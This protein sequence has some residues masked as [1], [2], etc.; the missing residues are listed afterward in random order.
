MAKKTTLPNMEVKKKPR[1]RRKPMSEEQ[2]I[3]AAERLAAAREKRQA[4]NP[5]AYANVNAR[6]NDQ[7]DDYPLSRKNVMD[8]IKTNKEELKEARAAVRQKVKGAEARES[9]VSGYIRNMEKYLRDGD[10]PDMFYGRN[11]ENKVRN[12]CIALSYHWTGPNKGMPKRDVGTFY[13]DICTVWEQDMYEQ[14]EYVGYS[15]YIG[16]SV[17]T[18]KTKSKKPSGEPASKTDAVLRKNIKKRTK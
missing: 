5:P 3:K 7:P 18:K 13:P 17:A 12:R 11:Q 10:W 8:W 6:V 9:H 15:R 16:D 2:K 1:K 4:N 14:Y